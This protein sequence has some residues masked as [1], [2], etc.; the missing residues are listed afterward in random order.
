MKFGCKT[1]ARDFRTST[2]NRN[3]FGKVEYFYHPSGWPQGFV[4]AA[5]VRKSVEKGQFCRA[6]A[7]KY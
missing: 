6:L 5:P 4:Q 7:G 2:E 1:D 3:K